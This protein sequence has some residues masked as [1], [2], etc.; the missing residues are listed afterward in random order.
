MNAAK[1]SGIK[2]IE[3]AIAAEDDKDLRRALSEYE[4][5]LGLLMQA[6]KLSSSSSE[7]GKLKK[8]VSQYMERAE[9]IKHACGD[10]SE[11][12]QRSKARKSGKGVP[13]AMRSLIERVLYSN[14]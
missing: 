13:K 5:G 7:R 10:Y 12:F 4:S 2:H 1:S 14:K 6:M 9:Y 3:A 8:L 11:E